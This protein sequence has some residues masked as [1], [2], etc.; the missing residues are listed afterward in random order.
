[1]L[2]FSNRKTTRR[3]AVNIEMKGQSKYVGGF[4]PGR[5]YFSVF[6]S[7]KK[8]LYVYNLNK[9]KSMSN[10]KNEL[11]TL[12]FYYVKLNY[13]SVYRQLLFLNIF[14]PYSNFASRIFW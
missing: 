4:S 6:S 5:R 11:L 9:F 7:P 8:T 13:T 1:M 14:F 3:R 10:A 2:A 12:C